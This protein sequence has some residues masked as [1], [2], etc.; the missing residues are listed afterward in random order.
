MRIIYIHYTLDSCE[1]LLPFEPCRA[2]GALFSTLTLGRVPSGC[3][4]GGA[5]SN[6]RGDALRGRGAATTLKSTELCDPRD[7]SDV[8]ENKVAFFRRDCGT[9]FRTPSGITIESLEC[10]CR[11]AVNGSG[12]LWKET[13]PRR[14]LLLESLP[15][16]LLAYKLRR[17]SEESYDR[18]AEGMSDSCCG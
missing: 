15:K 4:C 1:T 2:K 13:S 14:E 10:W 11:L 8:G 17:G 9:N 12:T 5:R 18:A 16:T 6:T 7:R 3:G